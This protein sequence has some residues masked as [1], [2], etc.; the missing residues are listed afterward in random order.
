MGDSLTDVHHDAR[1]LT[2]GARLEDAQAAVLACHGRGGTAEDILSVASAL[3]VPGVA[4]LAPQAHGHA[5]YPNSF[6]APIKANEPYLSSALALLGRLLEQIGTQGPPIE[7]TLL[8]GFSQG[9]CLALEFV[10]R[11]ARRY[12][13]VV[14]WS[15]GLIGPPGT[16]R[17]YSGSLDGTPIFLGSSDTDPHV[18]VE[19][20]RETAEVLGALGADVDLRIYPGMG[21]T[22]NSE[23]L[24]R[25]QSMLQHLVS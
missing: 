10:A 14:G 13:G 11:N 20:V 6:L 21:H 3:K 1:V 24:E 25:A 22:V 7:R 18:P 15:G 8:L 2:A 4:Y 23:E 19:R 16:P 9:A 5:W 17:E 12:G